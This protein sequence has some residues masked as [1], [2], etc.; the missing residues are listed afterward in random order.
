[1]G[2]RPLYAVFDLAAVIVAVV[3]YVTLELDVRRQRRLAEA[4]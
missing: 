3:G 2:F 1:V 4:E